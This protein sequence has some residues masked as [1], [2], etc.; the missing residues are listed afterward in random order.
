MRYLSLLTLVAVLA[1]VAFPFADPAAGAP[2]GDGWGTVT[3][4]I[5]WGGN[6]LPEP[7]KLTVDKDQAHCLAKGDIFSEEWV[8]NKNNKGV[9][10]VVVWLAPEGNDKLPI[11]PNLKAPPKEAVVMDQPFCRFAPHVVALRQGQTFTA[12]NSASIAHNFKWSGIKPTQGDNRSMPPN[13]SFD[14]KDLK[15]SP[16]PV[17]VECNIHGWM[18]AVI[19]VF[20][21][22]YYA[23][24]DENGKF[25]IK[26]APAG[27]CRLV[28]WHEPIGF[29]IDRKGEPIEIK[30]GGTTDVGKFDLK[31][32]EK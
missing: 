1:G 25:E 16:Y 30:A 20:D 7:R 29:R 23:V 32:R 2:N 28:I 10:W 14:I 8:V 9:R 6:G 31:P 5:V 27:K 18:K 24:T 17:N 26:N 13:T 19:Y 11:H 15:A 21:H 12:K 3:G 4:Q 22:P